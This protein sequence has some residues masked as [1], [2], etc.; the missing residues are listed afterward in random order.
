MAVRTYMPMLLL[1][2][3]A[4][5]KFCGKY[6]QEIRQGLVDQGIPVTLYDTLLAA[7]RALSGPLDAAISP[8]NP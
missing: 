4:L 2:S 7:L 8:K 6:D 5:Q 1:L 3:K